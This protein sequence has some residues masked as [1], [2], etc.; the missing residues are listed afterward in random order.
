MDSLLPEH[1]C[2][3]C[4]ARPMRSAQPA[5]WE[6][7]NVSG[8]CRSSLS[9]TPA[10]RAPSHVAACAGRTVTRVAAGQEHSLALGAGG[11]VW[12]FGHGSYGQ[13]GL[14]PSECAVGCVRLRASACWC[15]CAHSTVCE[16][17]Q[18]CA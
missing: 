16:C 7:P 4:D 2:K 8:A 14:G 18:E 13:L 12:A 11:E 6:W 15:A 3:R 9:L 5:R 1:L 17:V 10:V